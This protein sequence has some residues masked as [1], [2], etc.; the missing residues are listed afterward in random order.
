MS[1]TTAQWLSV[2]EAAAHLG[3]SVHTVRRRIADGT[4]PANRIGRLIRISVDALDNPGR[5]IPSA[6]AR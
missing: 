6:R 4:F 2:D 5:E 1:T 3:V